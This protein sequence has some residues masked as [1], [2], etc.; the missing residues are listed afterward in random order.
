MTHAR[1]DSP[2]AELSRLYGR[3]C[4]ATRELQFILQFLPDRFRVTDR[5]IA[6]GRGITPEEI[7][8]KGEALKLRASDALVA[9]GELYV[10][11]LDL[12]AE[13]TRRAQEAEA[14]A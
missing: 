3:A 8:Q 10:A 2:T 1:L 11:A 6:N 9:I 14:A 4:D 5:V 7:R 12:N 13:T